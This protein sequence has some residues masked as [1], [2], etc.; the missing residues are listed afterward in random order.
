MISA[1]TGM[2]AQRPADHHARTG[3]N[4]GGL[5]S[6]PRGAVSIPSLQYLV[7]DIV[8]SDMNA[9][10]GSPEN[11]PLVGHPL[12]FVVL[13]EHESDLAAARAEFPGGQLIEEPSRTGG[14]LFWLY[15]VP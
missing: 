7:P 13:P 6:S 12:L 1:A 11:P 5:F 4:S 15:R 3:L 2:V 10:W 14:V 9:P 8:G